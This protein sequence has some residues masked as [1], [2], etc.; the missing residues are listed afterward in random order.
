M[1]AQRV[2]RIKAAMKAGKLDALILRMPENIVMGFGVWPMNGFSY[3]VFTAD[4]GPAAVVAPSCEDQ[5]MDECWAPDVRFFVWPRLAMPDPLEAV[6]GELRQIAK[7]HGLTKAR[8]GYEGGF[9]CVAPPHN[10]AEPMVACEGSI[11]YLKSILPAAKWRDATDLLHAQRATKTAR[12]IAKLR[13]AHKVAD[14]GLRKFMGSVRPGVSEAELAGI[15]YSECLA[16]G[17]RLQGVRHVNPYPQVSSG[18]NTYRAWRPV[19]TTGK[20]KLRNGEIALLELAVC[21]DGFWADVTRPKAAGE[22]S[23]VQKEAFAAVKAAQAAA[24]KCIRPGVKTSLPDSISRRV[25]IDAGF[26]ADIVHLTGHGIGFRYHEPEPVLID[27]PGSAKFKTGH[28]CSVE[29]GL[30]NRNWGGIRIEDNVAVTKGGAEIL[31]KAP[32]QL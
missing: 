31:T 25:L 8:I 27:A 14:F 22:P 15:V 10:A 24:V 11:A 1:D 7:S 4:A 30:Y 32:K 19:V 29:P 28:V 26:E 6:R 20:R 2:R 18:C 17:V 12:E 21:V 13:V 9:E 16:R 5:E 23:K 3:A